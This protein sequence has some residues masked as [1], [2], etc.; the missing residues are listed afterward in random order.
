LAGF[1]L[2][3]LSPAFLSFF[4]WPMPDREAA[5]V[6]HLN[7]APII[8]MNLRTLQKMRFLLFIAVALFTSQVFAAE[9]GRY[10][11]CEWALLDTGEVLRAA[12]DCTLTR[13]PNCNEVTVD[14]KIL[15]VYHTDGTAEC[16]DETFTKVL[17]EKGRRDNA[18]I[19]LGF[20]LPYFTV[21]VA[22]L[23]VIK[24]DGGVVPVNIDA[25]SK[26]SIDNSQMDENIY[27]PNSRIL[28]VNVPGLEIGDIVHTVTRTTVERPIIPNGFADDFLFEGQGYIRHISCEIRGPA[29]APLRH[30]ALRD[31]VDDTVAATTRPGRDGMMVYHWE[32][33]GVPRMYD[34]PAM[35]PYEMVSQRLLVSTLP[36]WAAVSR[37]YWKLSQSH[38][39]ATSQAMRRIVAALTTGATTDL[40]KIKA[41]FY[42]VSKAIR[43]MGVTPEKDRPGFEPHD[44]S[45]T[46]AKKYGVCRDKAALLVAMLRMAG[47]KAYPVLINVGSRMDP[48][49]PD[50]YFNH[51]IAAVEAA[52][53]HYLLMDPTDEHTRVLLP[54]YDD[55]QSYLVC[56][57]EGDNL[58]L[59]PIMP[60]GENMMRIRTTGALDTDGTLTA[61]SELSFGGIN[62]DAYRGG[63]AEMKPDGRQRFFESRLQQVMP[64]VRLT[65]L[66]ITPENMLDESVPLRAEISFSAP[67]MAAF[68]DDR[69][70]V[71]MPWIGNDLGAVNFILGGTGLERRKYPMETQM[72]CGIDEHITLKLAS[73]FSRAISIPTASSEEDDCVSY[74]RHFGFTDHTLDASKDLQLKVVEFSPKQYL[75]LKRTLANFDYD[76]RKSP[77]IETI[78]PRPSAAVAP[79]SGKS[80]PRITSNA[81][82]LEDRQ[83]LTVED[84]HTAVLRVHYVKRILSY[85]GKIGESEVKIPY[86]PATERVRIIHA[87]V[88]SESGQRQEVSKDEVN[89]MDAEWNSS[90]E[91]YTGGKILVDSLPGVEIGSTIEVAYEV[92][93]KGRPYLS[94]FQPFQLPDEIER[95]SFEITAPAGLHVRTLE[96]GP[97]GI[98]TGEKKTV[99]GRET[100][101]WRARQVGALPEESELPPAWSFQAGVAYYVGDP[102]A[103][104]KE[105]KD[106]M[107]AHAARGAQAREVARRLAGRSKT[108]LEAVEAIRDYVAESVR[109]AGPSFTELPLSE[110]SDADTTLT[111]GYGHAADRAILLQAMLAA[112]GFH[113]EF[114]LA[115]D[116]PA[117]AGLAGTARSFPLPDEFDTP[118]VRIVVGGATYYL[119]DTDQYARLGSTPHDGY[120][121]ID[122][123]TGACETIRA[124]GDCHDRVATTYSLMLDDQGNARIG[125]RYEYYGMAFDRKNRRFSRMRPE[126]R[127]QYFQ[128]AVSGVAQGARPVGG[129][130]TDFKVYPG[131]ERFEVDVDRYG[132][133]NDR[134]LYFSLP[135]TPQLFE[136]DTNRRTLPLL[137]SDLS[138]EII[139]ARI[140]LPTKYRQVAIAP[141]AAS[142]AGPDGAGTAHVVS[143]TRHGDHVITYQLEHRPAII[144]PADY[145]AALAVES[146]LENKAAR[147]VLLE[148]DK[149]GPQS[150]DK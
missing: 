112:A 26:E 57:P 38:L 23:E 126:E 110:L 67:S 46:F 134:C 129:L 147:V 75:E 94:G 130:V 127:A 29:T 138:D 124:A 10:A 123:A 128:E 95:K 36:D 121:S 15:E 25:N 106:E 21:Q 42:Y 39:D 19:S 141:R 12:A 142:F 77:V 55:N 111:D 35:P 66:R 50:P 14:E 49:V 52:P 109:L 58:H 113:P 89:V 73:N 60:P 80:E 119:N 34:E 59:S 120:L 30:I 85:A 17:T 18:V 86:N 7:A 133:A 91:R 11:G 135:F 41:V 53:G 131:V 69:A 108:K 37:W 101:Q 107:L 74:R 93:M 81:T 33:N 16:Q 102:A 63:F 62:G 44:V 71:S 28:Q 145:P 136:T 84:A 6:G 122:P 48:E 78:G 70:V 32:V 132:V 83:E 72:T 54:A 82:I 51:A 9:A 76:E 116:L 47:L 27:D 92:A 64:G 68:G 125:I 99:D 20:L 2:E 40:D 149:T 31:K 3:K 98:V 144:H 150:R 117:V 140:K 118:L 104:Y 1:N 88:V 137:I 87:A 4:D 56:R 103:Y 43:Y 96:T 5:A 105:L 79:V 146:A 24:P 61:T 13:F 90:A 115:A 65:A 97:E 22:R 148:R 114:V 8:L 100:L 143:T 139:R 45:L